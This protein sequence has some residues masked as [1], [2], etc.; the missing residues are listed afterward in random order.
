MRTSRDILAEDIQEAVAAAKK[1]GYPV[2]M[3]IVSPEILHKTDVGG[4][5]LGVKD[6][7]GVRDAYMQI[8]SRARKLMPDATILGVSVQ[9]MVPK[10]REVIIGATR[11]PQFGPMI[12]FG[13]GGIYVEVLKDVAFRVAPLTDKDA[14]DMVHEIRT[15]PLLMGVRGEPPVD[16]PTVYQYILRISQLMIDFPEIDQIDLNP[17]LVQP[18]GKGAFAID[19]RFILREE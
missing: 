1:L 17:L 16:L 9:E 14:R 3:K 15:Y 12:M 6:A 7:D 5:I 8:V 10:G 19:A 2:V 13:L 11:D 18:Q 4:V